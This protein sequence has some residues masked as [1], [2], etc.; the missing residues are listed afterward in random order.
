MRALACIL[1]TI[2]H[3][4]CFGFRFYGEQ[5]RIVSWRKVLQDHADRWS[6]FVCSEQH[7]LGGHDSKRQCR[8]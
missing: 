3:T 5:F 8:D 2:I 1:T 7:T 6:D 4:H